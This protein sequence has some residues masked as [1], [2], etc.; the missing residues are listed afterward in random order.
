MHSRLP[1]H[2][3]ANL[4]PAGHPCRPAVRGLQ[5]PGTRLNDGRAGQVLVQSSWCIGALHAWGTRRLL[6]CAASS[7]HDCAHAVRMRA[8]CKQPALPPLACAAGTWTCANGAVWNLSSPR[9]LQRPLGWTAGDAAGLPIWA[10][11][12]T[13]S[14]ILRGAVSHAVRWVVVSCTA[15]GAKGRRCCAACMP[16]APSSPKRHCPTPVSRGLPDGT[17]VLLPPPPPKCRFTAPTV[18]TAYAYPAGHLVD[19]GG[20]GDAGWMGMRARVRAGFPCW[21]LQTWAARV[22]CRGL[23]QYGMILADV[24]SPWYLTG[25]ATP[26]WEARMG[27]NYDQCEWSAAQGGRG[28]GAGGQAFVPRLQAPGWQRSWARPGANI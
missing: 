24:G 14:D 15:L 27:P 2:A 17:P 22:I 5:L 12:I 7:V 6:H 1:L 10:G 16:G 13:L 3:C 28:A 9:L 19:V 21:A 11:L 20:S 18:R 8:P 4:L 23:K 25:E 26:A